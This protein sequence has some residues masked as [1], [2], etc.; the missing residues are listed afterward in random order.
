MNYMRGFMDL[1]E[2]RQLNYEPASQKD[3]KEGDKDTQGVVISEPDPTQLSLLFVLTKAGRFLRSWWSAR[4][5]GNLGLGP[6]VIGV[7]ISGQD[8][9]QLNLLSV[10]RGWR[11]S[12]VVKKC[13]LLVLEIMLAGT[14]TC[15]KNKIDNSLKNT[16]IYRIKNTF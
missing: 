10:L 8:L 9:I 5:R 12:S 11:D 15:A 1:R 6:G 13:L 2:E 3:I 7:V 4:D 14:H 16:T